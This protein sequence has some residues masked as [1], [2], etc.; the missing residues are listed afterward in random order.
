MCAAC[1]TDD[2]PMLCRCEN[3]E[4]GQHR[5]RGQA[6]FLCVSAWQTLAFVCAHTERRAGMAAHLKEM[7]PLYF[8]STRRLS[9]KICTPPNALVPVVAWRRRAFRPCNAQP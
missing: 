2:A 9:G 3:R 7:N 6:R 1:D 5:E 4:R 8:N